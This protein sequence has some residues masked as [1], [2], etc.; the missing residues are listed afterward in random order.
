M[1]PPEFKPKELQKAEEYFKEVH[2]TQEQHKIFN[3][4]VDI[5]LKHVPM[6]EISAK[7]IGWRAVK[8]W[9]LKHKRDLLGLEDET[10]EER[11]ES[12]EELLEIVKDDLKE[13]LKDQVQGPEIDK[14]MANI[15]EF[16]RNKY[17][18]R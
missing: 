12:I 14:A 17:A 13:I 11:V 8:K 3:D 18:A 15:L 2:M 5:F 4:F 9:Q 1:E 10:E 7:G 16:Y 6:N